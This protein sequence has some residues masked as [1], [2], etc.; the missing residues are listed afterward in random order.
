M[1][2]INQEQAERD[3]QR[4][5]ANREELVQRIGRAVQEDGTVELL[6]GLYLS[7]STLPLA[8]VHSVTKPSFCVIAQGSKEILLGDSRYRYDARHYFIATVE[9]PRVSQI[10]EASKERPYL[11]L[12][13]ELAPT[14]VGSVM[15]D[16][17]HVPTPA[18][19]N[20]R[21]IDVSPLDVS[22]Q[23]AVVRLVRLLDSPAEAPVLQPLI[24]REIVYRLLIGS[25]GARLRYLAVLGGYTSHIARA[26]ERIRRDFD[27]PLRIEDLARELGM[28]VSGLQHHFKAVTA[29]SPMQYQKQ[30]RLQEARRLM[31]SEQLDAASAGFRVGYHEASHFNREYKSLFGVPP[32][33]DVQQLR[34]EALEN[35][36]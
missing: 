36:G 21:A 25:Q 3:A 28:S 22:L 27:Q 19:P 15:E 6:E 24:T 5:Q 9:L 32:M 18:H 2:G 4:E 1:G 26:V 31:L 7:R 14:L 13:L 29:M 17:R 35:A 20:V 34:E 23:D 33:R 16:T 12:R 8:H 11:S 10:L 30:L